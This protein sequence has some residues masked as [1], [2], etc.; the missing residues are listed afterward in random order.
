MESTLKVTVRYDGTGFAGWQVQPDRRTVQGELQRVLSQIASRTVHVFG[1]SRTDAGVHALGQVFSCQWRGPLAP[2]RL[3]RSLS[4]MLGPE[5]RIECIEE[6]APEFHARKCARR[7]RYAYTLSLAQHADP[8]SARYAWH[9]PWAIDLECLAQLARRLEGKHDFAGFQASGATVKTTVR[10]VESVGVRPGGIIGPCDAEGLMHIEF[11][12]DGFLYKM[13]RNLVGT[14]VDIARGV[15]PEAR[16][17]DLL[18][19]PGPYCGHTAPAHG[20]VLL[21]VIY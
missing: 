6:V 18:A 15:M 17:E 11:C 19:S 5:I 8:F 16:L 3:Q 13:V 4:Q 14:L 2:E 10:T 12:A 20:L 21:E 9:V 1:A 7:K